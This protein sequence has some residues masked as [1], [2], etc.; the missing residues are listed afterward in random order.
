MIEQE[1][2]VPCGEIE[3]K[4]LL[5]VPDGDGPFPAFLYV[6]GSGPIDRDDNISGMPL[7][8]SKII[9]EH[10]AQQGIASLRYDKRGVGESSG[11][12]DLATYTDLVDD[13]AA[14]ANFLI[15]HTAT[16]P[17]KIYIVG[18]SEGT[19]IAPQVAI[20][21][22][23]VA[24]II[25]LSPFY[26]DAESL[27]MMQAKAMQEMV[28]KS[29]GFRAGIW[30]LLAF[31][32]DPVKSQRKL[33]N[34]IKTTDK[35][36]VRA[37]LAGKI[38]VIWVRELFELDPEDIFRQSVTP[39]LLIGGSKDFQCGPADVAKI[40][41]IYGGEV[42]G[43]VVENMSHLLRKEENEPSIFNYQD[44]SKEPLLPE[45]LQLIE[46]WLQRQISR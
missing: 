27:L 9:A 15:Q 21:N 23:K 3:L 8:N 19:I 5:C 20:K 33:I 4:G 39:A 35:K 17:D 6:S 29:K 43:H 40:E 32:F 1:V 28:Q 12:F 45:V 10:L 26:E 34:K 2:T 11:D 24:G 25:L 16:N 30:K 18:H 36:V 46:A 37:G 44:Q 7:N 14:C 38:S 31:I 42:E 22:N 41:K 13:A